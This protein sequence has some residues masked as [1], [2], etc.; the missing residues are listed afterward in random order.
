MAEEKKVLEPD[1]QL[2]EVGEWTPVLACPNCRDQSQI[3]DFAINVLATRPTTKWSICGGCGHVF[4]NPQPSEAWMAN[5]YK[6]G[7][8]RMTHG[9]K[10]ENPKVVPKQSGEEEMMR[11]ARIISALDRIMGLPTI[12]S[13]LDMGSSTGAL[14]A[15]LMHKFSCKYAVGVEPGDAWREFSNNSY[16]QFMGK[17][18]ELNIEN[19]QFLTFKTLDEVPRER[20]F[21]LVTIIHTLEHMSDPRTVL[22]T[23]REHY[24]K[25]D[26]LLVLAMPYIFGGAPDPLMFPHLHAFRMET[27]FDML[28]RA[29][30]NI[31][32]FETGDINRPFWMA[33][34]D[35]W[36]YASPKSNDLGDRFDT[37]R[38]YNNQRAAVAKIRSAS[39][40]MTPT[41][42]MG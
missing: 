13:C 16:T 39:Q 19:S 20:K 30:W 21:D 40:N 35:I 29:G 10:E 9:L 32:L 7:Y 5:F 11:G 26:G 23:V 22:E 24:I 17:A 31:H 25:G 37:L 15:G 2:V 8:R 27:A 4:C 41:Y 38:L 34:Q 42:T 3:K 36:V 6:N 33:P 14:L 28:K 1:I 12:P 18:K